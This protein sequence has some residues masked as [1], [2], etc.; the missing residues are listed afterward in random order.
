[1]IL[2][3]DILKLHRFSIE[4]Y[5]GAAG[6]RDLGLPESAIARSFQTF[7]GDDLYQ[8]FLKKQQH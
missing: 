2:V 4:I 8:R 5:G 3:E 7:G 6:V 1:M